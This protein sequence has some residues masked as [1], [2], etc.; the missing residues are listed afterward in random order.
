MSERPAGEAFGSGLGGSGD[1]PVV[2]NAADTESLKTVR[3]VAGYHRA[4]DFICAR[5]PRVQGFFSRELPRF[6]DFSVGGYCRVFILPDPAEPTGVWGYYTLS[7]SELKL[8]NLT[9][10]QQKQFLGSL[11]IPLARVGFMGRDDRS[12]S[13]LGKALLIDAARRVHRSEDMTAM[14]LILDAEGG[15]STKL[16]SWYRDTMQFVPLRDANNAETGALYC[17]L[18]RLLPELQ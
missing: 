14:G 12:P 7:P 11:P 8:G 5:S 3:F 2:A 9:K 4:A 13:G 10:S 18:R 16:F 15:P 1:A 6:T 17:P